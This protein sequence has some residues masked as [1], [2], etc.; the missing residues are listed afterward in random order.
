M[1]GTVSCRD[2]EPITAKRGLRS[3]FVAVSWG[4]AAASANW[5]TFG[6]EMPEESRGKSGTIRM[7]SG[8]TVP[9]ARPLRFSD[10][11]GEQDRAD[12]AGDA[13]TPEVPPAKPKQPGS[14][15]Q[16][17]FITAPRKPVGRTLELRSVDVSKADPRQ[18]P[19]QLALRTLEVD[20]SLGPESQAEAQAKPT[21]WALVIGIALAVFVVGIVVVA[22]GFR[23]H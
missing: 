18:A 8:A 14:D 5:G 21:N 10:D 3:E 15:R 9:E 16:E 17:S 6:N 20:P 4:P 1:N 22:F 23:G 2:V 13:P 11:I 7:D 19:T 12:L